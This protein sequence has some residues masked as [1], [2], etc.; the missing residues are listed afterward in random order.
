MLPKDDEETAQTER[1]TGARR[2]GLWKVLAL[3][4]V[5]VVAGFG[6]IAGLTA[7]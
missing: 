4:L 6:I 7:H 2:V 3:S 1:I 5:I